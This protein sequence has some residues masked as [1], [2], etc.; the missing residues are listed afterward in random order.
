MRISQT[1]TADQLEP[2]LVDKNTP[3]SYV[4]ANIFFPLIANDNTSGFVKPLLTAFQLEPLLVDKNTPPSVPAKIFEP[5]IEIASTKFASDTESNPLFIACQL[6]P[7]LVDKYTPLKVPTKILESV[8]AIELIYWGNPFKPFVSAIQLEP[9][10]VDKYIPALLW[11]KCL[12][13][14]WQMKL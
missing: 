6:L 1:M 14:L 8:M 12:S 11:Q 2:L 10:F 3:S 5:L 4:P 13:R 9:L 7:K